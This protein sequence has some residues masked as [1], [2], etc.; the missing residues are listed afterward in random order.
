[1]GC[2]GP[3]GIT[4]DADCVAG[5]AGCVVVAG[6]LDPGIGAGLGADGKGLAGIDRERFTSPE[7]APGAAGVASGG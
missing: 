7:G 5:G 6:R 4:G 2:L 1:M 3:D